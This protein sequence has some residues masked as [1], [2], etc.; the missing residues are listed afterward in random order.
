MQDS[1]RRDF[2]K[3]VA[4]P[5][6]T[7]AVAPLFVPRSAFGANDRPAYGVIATGGRGRYLNKK[8]MKT[9]CQPVAMCDVYEPNLQ[10]ALSDSPGAKGYVD[11]QELLA[12]P[13]TYQRLYNMQFGDGPDAHDGGIDPAIMLAVKEM[14]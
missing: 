5:A 13:G 3:G 9:G 8:F 14:F 1:N 10:A 12:Q 6:A 7:L 11:Y 2:L 4:V